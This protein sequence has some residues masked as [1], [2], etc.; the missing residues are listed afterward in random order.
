M[1]EKDYLK[2]TKHGDIKTVH[3][4]AGKSRRE[5][6]LDVFWLVKL[7]ETTS[8]VTAATGI[9][10]SYQVSTAPMCD[11]GWRNES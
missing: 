1:E 7:A 6:L 10:A 5:C 11:F 8:A 2:T 4:R 9:V 3:F